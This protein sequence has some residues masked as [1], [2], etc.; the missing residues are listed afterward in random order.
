[1]IS[2][3]TAL[4]EV[5][6]HDAMAERVGAGGCSALT[7][8]STWRFCRREVSVVHAGR[9]KRETTSSLAPQRFKPFGT[10]ASLVRR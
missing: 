6:H 9:N 1:M 5:I 4:V 8:C 10:S 2:V 3:E 7:A